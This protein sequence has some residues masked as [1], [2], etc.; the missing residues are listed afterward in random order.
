LN[1]KAVRFLI[2]DVLK[3]FSWRSKYYQNN[4]YIIKQF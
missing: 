3:Y 4:D 2:P 1:K